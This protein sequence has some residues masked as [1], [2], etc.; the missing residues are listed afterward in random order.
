GKSTVIWLLLR[1]YDPQQG[2]VLVGGRDV[3]EWPLDALHG[4]IAVVAQ[5]TYLFHGTVAENLRIGRPDATDEQLRE[6]ARAANA[7]D[8]IMAL[9]QG[10]ETIVGERG[11]RLSG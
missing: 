11:T 7:D 5:D 1:F 2:R 6:T 4:M 3:R 9:P 10:Y 8:F